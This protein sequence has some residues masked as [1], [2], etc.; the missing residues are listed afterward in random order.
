MKPN[1]VSTVADYY[2]DFIALKEAPAVFQLS[3]GMIAFLADAI[4]R[5]GVTLADLALQTLSRP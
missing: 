2:A 4:Y 1:S 3:G 5:K